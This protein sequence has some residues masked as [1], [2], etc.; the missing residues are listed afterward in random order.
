M[1]WP[2]K[3]V[4]ASNAD[5]WIGLVSLVVFL[6]LVLYAGIKFRKHRM[7]FKH[8]LGFLLIGYEIFL[9][10]Y[11]YY[12]GVW[13]MEHSLP[14]HLCDIA[15]YTVIFLLFRFNQTLFEFTLLLGLAGSLQ[16]FITPEI[17][18]MPKMEYFIRYF[19]SHA[20]N[21]VIPLYFF[22]VE[23]RD[24]RSDA[25]WRV[26]RIGLFLIVVVGTIDLAFGWN[27]MYLIHPPHVTSIFVWRPAP[28]HVVGFIIMG[29]LHVYG[30]YWLFNYIQQRRHKWKWTVL[31]WVAWLDLMRL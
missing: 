29:A 26:F 19:F 20:V 3:F 22:F 25:F 1:K 7:S 16:G 27:Y 5:Q 4:E 10:G 15:R 6:V 11:E 24:I 2:R 21:I 14:L 12:L 13:S 18:N 17:P 8:F 23:G 28:M 30:L 9:N 31:R